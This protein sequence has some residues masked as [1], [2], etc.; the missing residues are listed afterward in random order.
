M[1]KIT[2][3]YESKKKKTE[4]YPNVRTTKLCY[5]KHGLW[6][7]KLYCFKKIFVQR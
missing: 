3:L 4:F 5:D 1:W 7:L 2:C 6:V